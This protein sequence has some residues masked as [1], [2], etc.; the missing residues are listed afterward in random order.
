MAYQ[1]KELQRE[2][3]R[4]RVER[5][6]ALQGKRY[7]SVTGAV[8]PRGSG[9]WGSPPD[10][11]NPPSPSKERGSIEKRAASPPSKI[12]PSLL[13]KEWGIKARAKMGFEA[14]P[15]RGELDGDGNPIP[16]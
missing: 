3:T 12:P 13:R 4:A 8:R 1:D 5:W 6:R 9:V 15:V 10:Y 14:P 16:S 11:L 2:T 7:K